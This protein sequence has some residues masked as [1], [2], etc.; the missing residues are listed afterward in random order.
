MAAPDVPSE[1]REKLTERVNIS[2]FSDALMTKRM[3]R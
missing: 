1:E 2:A 3:M